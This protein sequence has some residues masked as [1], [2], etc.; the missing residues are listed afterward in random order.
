[1]AGKTVKGRQGRMK[2]IWRQGRLVG[3]GH[4]AHYSYVQDVRKFR[5][6]VEVASQGH[7]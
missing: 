2:G 3:C 5:K 4:L 6:V 1:M 7:F